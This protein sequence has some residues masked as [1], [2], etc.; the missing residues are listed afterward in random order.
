M[1]DGESHAPVLEATA[2]AATGAPEPEM[3]LSEDGAAEFQAAQL[4][5]AA[6]LEAS[7]GTPEDAAAEFQA[8]QV[9]LAAP[10]EASTGLLG[11]AEAEAEFQAAQLEAA[12]LEA[13]A[14]E[15]AAPEAPC[16]LPASGV[17]VVEQEVEVLV[18]TGTEMVHG[19]SVTVRVEAEVTV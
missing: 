4:E 7:T 3:V 18:Q 13:A 17:A 11:D 10:L 8:A 1:A 5:A 9:E 2:T 12:A 19:Q 6:M 15:A 14:L 16:G